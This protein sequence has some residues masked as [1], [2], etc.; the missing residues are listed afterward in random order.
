MSMQKFSLIITAGGTSSRY[1]NTNKLLEKIDSMT[2]IEHSVRPFKNFEEIDEIIIPANISIK[3]DLAEIFSGSE[4]IIIEGGQTR[5][6]SVYKALQKVKN[7]YVIIHDG[8]R[9]LINEKIIRE[10]LDKTVKYNAV[11]VMTKTTDTIKEVDEN[12]RI[13]RT[14]DR[15]KLYNT[16]TPQAFKTLLIKDAHEKL[17][18]KSFTDDSSML[19]E[20]GIDVYIAEGSPMNIKITSKSDLDFAK[21]YI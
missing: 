5:Q 18:G 10:V 14:I 15:T 4:I 19:E 11:S 1:G 13:I 7:D 21:L 6:E 9:P 12:G 8:A 16:Q 17:Q 2:V 20:L 3:K